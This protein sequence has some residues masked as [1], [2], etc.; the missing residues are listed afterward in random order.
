MPS[1]RD[2]SPLVRRCGT[3]RRGRA[4]L[5]GSGLDRPRPGPGTRGG[6]Q[7]NDYQRNQQQPA[8][9][10]LPTDHAGEIRL[11]V[12]HV[13]LHEVREAALLRRELLEVGGRGDPDRATLFFNLQLYR[14]AFGF[15]HMGYASAMAWLLFIVVLGLTIVLFKT[16]GSWVYAGGER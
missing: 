2:C 5:G 14:E 7:R 6:Y 8:G 9:F 4:G 10:P 1:C 16:A 11:E 13:E 3:E 15:F 12:L